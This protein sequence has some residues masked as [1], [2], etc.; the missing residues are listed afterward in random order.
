MLTNNFKLF[1]ILMVILF[2][3]PSSIFAAS[4]GIYAD[5]GSGSGEADVD[6]IGLDDID[7]DTN[8]VG[9]GFQMETDPMSKNRVF[10]YRCQAGLEARD[11]KEKDGVTFELAGVMLNNT[12]A[13]GSNVSDNVR[14]WVGP[15]VQI[16]LYAGETD[17][18]YLGDDI[19]FAGVLFGL[20]I[21]GGANFALGNDAP[22][23]TATVGVR[24]FGMV[25]ATE[26]FDDDDDMTA[27][28]SEI[29]A[30]VGIM[31]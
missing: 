27:N 21:A 15:Q 16:G 17:E 6:T 9:L 7:I 12:F 28:G 5:Y 19:S 24:S 26:W 30:S 1:C 10:S 2:F 20:G 25:G 3:L 14:I 18:P 23:I 4:F 13:F 29:V 11:L 8:L 31:F 22:I